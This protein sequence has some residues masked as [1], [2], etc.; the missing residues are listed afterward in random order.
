MNAIAPAENIAVKRT[1]INPKNN[2]IRIIPAMIFT[3]GDA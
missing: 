3:M 2:P 1:G